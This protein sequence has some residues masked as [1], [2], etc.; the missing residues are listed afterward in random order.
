M[1]GCMDVRTSRCMNVCN[2]PSL[3]QT[4]RSALPVRV[5]SRSLRLW[6]VARPSPAL[7]AAH[8]PRHAMMMEEGKKREGFLMHIYIVT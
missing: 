3:T 5:G 7:P 6:P 8:H 4:G 2:T 1:H